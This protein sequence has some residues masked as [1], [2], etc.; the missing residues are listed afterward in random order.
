MAWIEK[1]GN[2]FRV[3]WRTGGRNGKKRSKTA[4]SREAAEAALA[5]IESQASAPSSGNFWDRRGGPC[6]INELSEAWLSDFSATKQ[7]STKVKADATRIKHIQR[8]LGTLDV[9]QLNQARVNI[10]VSALM[11]RALRGTTV[12]GIVSTL[13]TIVNAA[14]DNGIVQREELP[15]VRWHRAISDLNSLDVDG[16]SKQDTWTREEVARILSAFEGTRL[17]LPLLISFNTGMRQGEM[18]SLPWSAIDWERKRVRIGRSARYGGGTKGVKNRKP[19]WCP[20]NAE[21]ETGLLQQLERHRRGALQGRP[22]PELI[23]P[24]PAGGIWDSSNF[25]S[26]WRSARNVLLAN[27]VRLLTW[28]CTRHTFV[29][30]LLQSGVPIATVADWIGD[31][32]KTVEK[33]YSHISTGQQMTT[34]CLDFSLPGASEVPH[35][36]S[37]AAQETTF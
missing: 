6:F 14:K 13:R 5:A 7:E 19:H 1:Q 22:I 36:S 32:V 12:A 24:G 31:A 21:L 17:H 15:R 37:R 34:D 27:R 8:E 26:A 28:H 11:E 2:S 29:T 33:H 25:R 18:L 20:M 35:R 10:F 9:R 4:S 23:V 30:H 3:C 16:E